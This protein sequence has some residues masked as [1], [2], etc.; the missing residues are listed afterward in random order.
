[1]KGGEAEE[2]AIPKDDLFPELSNFKS[3]NNI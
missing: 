2:S 3:I 1:M